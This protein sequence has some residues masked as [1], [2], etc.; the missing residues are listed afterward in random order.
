[1]SGALGK[2]CSVLHLG[3]W[4]EVA[5]QA[6]G[7]LQCGRGGLREGQLVPQGFRRGGL[8]QVL[9][10]QD[11]AAQGPKRRKLGLHKFE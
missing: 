2:A 5:A 9:P 6:A 8:H 11:C 10:L 1:V 7:E 3:V 4:Y